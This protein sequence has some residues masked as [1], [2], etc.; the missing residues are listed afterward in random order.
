MKSRLYQANGRSGAVDRFPLVLGRRR[1][2]LLPTRYGVVFSIALAAM[3]LGAANHNNNFAFLMTFLLAG[4]GLAGLFFG[5]RNLSGLEIQAVA[6]TPVFAGQK[7]VFTVSLRNPAG[8]RR[9]LEAAVDREGATRFSLAEG[10]TKSVD[11]FLPTRRRGRVGAAP[12]RLYSLYPM[13]LFQF[14]A[15]LR[16]DTRVTV[17]PEPAASEAQHTAEAGQSGSGSAGKSADAE[18]FDSL[19]PYRPGD[20]V[21]RIAWKAV[22]KERG[23]TVKHFSGAAGGAVLLD[24]SQV[25]ATDIEKR[26]SILTGWVLE[27]D[28]AGTA[29]GLRLPGRK[30]APGTGPPHRLDC[31]TAL[32]LFGFG[33]TEPEP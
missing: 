32:A 27:A 3:L 9:S 26:L 4:I 24:W 10:E 14:L 22:S 1:I 13:G 11:V 29:Y 6:G 30:V 20:P 19:R 5:H 15:V 12:L 18:D 33:K 21:R 17:F 31:L 8:S 2:R 25:P 28:R 23:L 7:A 16:P